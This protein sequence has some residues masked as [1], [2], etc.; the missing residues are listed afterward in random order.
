[1]CLEPLADPSA[2]TARKVQDDQARTT[3]LLC[4][5]TGGARGPAQGV[6]VWIQ[7]A[8]QPCNER[9]PSSDQQDCMCR[10]WRGCWTEPTRIPFL[11]KGVTRERSYLSCDV[12]TGI[13]PQVYVL[14]PA[15]I[16]AGSSPACQPP[17]IG[18]CKCSART[19]HAQHLGGML[20]RAPRGSRAIQGPARSWQFRRLWESRATARRT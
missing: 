12:W 2:T 20:C 5:R 11:R 7:R 10:H 3:H 1:M 8:L 17:A 14:L 18:L 6:P 19:Q 9:L 16:I 15:R 4:K 13:Q